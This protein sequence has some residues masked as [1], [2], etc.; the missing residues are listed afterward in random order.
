M[1]EISTKQLFVLLRS[2]HGFLLNL[3]GRPDYWGPQAGWHEQNDQL[4]SC[5]FFC[6]HSRWSLQVQ[7]AALSIYKITICKET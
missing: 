6:Q 5:D 4:F 7:G 3:L 2:D 1:T